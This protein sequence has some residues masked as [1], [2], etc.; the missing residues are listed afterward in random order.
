MSKPKSIDRNPPTSNRQLLILAGIFLAFIGLI[1]WGISWLFSALIYL[2][3]PKLEQQ[4]GAVVIPVYERQADKSEAVDNLNRLL[5][6]LENK[7]QTDE[8]QDRN[9]RILY[10]KEPTVNAMALPGDAIVIYQGLIEK[11]GSEN[12]LM[13]VLS[14]ELGHFAHRDHLR[15][16]GRSILL[17]VTLSYFFGDAGS[18]AGIAASIAANIS[19]A[20]Y[21]QSQEN[22][23]DE[24]GLDLLNKT[25][26]HVAG[27]TDFF[28]KMS[29]EKGINLA[30]LSTH[31]AAKER[32]QQLEKMIEEKQY[33]QQSLSPLTFSIK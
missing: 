22:E 24:F 32:V 26:G 16:L 12:E 14:H 10:I 30:F 8:K 15:G 9:Y 25:Y 11:M 33:S 18:L 7:L 29:Q 5:D 3:P 27:A 17:Q 2:I 31:P 13:M 23:A 21:S 1:I 20:S 4:L 6:R 19:N 28:R